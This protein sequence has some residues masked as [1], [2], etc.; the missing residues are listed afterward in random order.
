MHMDRIDSFYP[1]WP[2]FHCPCRNDNCT[3]P[4]VNLDSGRIYARA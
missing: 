3:A 2:P 4:N 1:F